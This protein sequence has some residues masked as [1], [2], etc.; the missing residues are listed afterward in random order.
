[1]LAGRWQE[2]DL[3]GCV[4]AWQCWRESEC[5]GRLLE[6]HGQDTEPE[7]HVS[8]YRVLHGRH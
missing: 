5:E 8:E 3:E 6:W 4:S 7:S 1:M 2:S